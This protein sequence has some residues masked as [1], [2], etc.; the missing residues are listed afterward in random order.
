MPR[1]VHIFEMWAQAVL[2]LVMLFLGIS[3][4]M[5]CLAALAV[6]GIRD[7]CQ[8]R[9]CFQGALVYAWMN[10]CTCLHMKFDS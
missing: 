1:A 8:H 5:V 7:F 4:V 9:P 2:N 6:I 10:E 3:F